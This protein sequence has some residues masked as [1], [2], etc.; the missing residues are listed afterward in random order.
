MNAGVRG[1]YGMKGT[2]KL[3]I[4]PSG[5]CVCSRCKTR[6]TKGSP[7]IVHQVGSGKW[8]RVSKYCSNCGVDILT[9]NI[10]ELWDYL[11][12]VACYNREVGNGR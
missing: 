11:A 5:R 1:K 9:A 8:Q 3:E 4:D 10:C 6:I 2:I 7:R 12:T